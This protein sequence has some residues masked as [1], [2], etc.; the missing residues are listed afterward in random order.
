MGKYFRSI[1]LR[2]DKT[3]ENVVEWKLLTAV[4]L[5]RGL[6]ALA[7]KVASIRA[8]AA[9]SFSPSRESDGDYKCNEIGSILQS[10]H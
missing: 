5:Y 4:P 3:R 10:T 1:L 7:R 8:L 9:T 2:Y 6:A